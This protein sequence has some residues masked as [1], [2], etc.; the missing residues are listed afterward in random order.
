MSLVF[1][2]AQMT[3]WQA[4]SGVIHSPSYFLQASAVCQTALVAGDAAI[5]RPMV[6]GFK[7]LT[8]T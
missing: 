7:D 1:S 3:Y 5:Q 6:S 4:G 8:V 2:W